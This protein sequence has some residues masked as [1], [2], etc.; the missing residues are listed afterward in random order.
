ML[1][2]GDTNIYMDAT[3]NPATEHFRAGWEACVFPEGHS[4]RRGRHH[5]HASPVPAPGGHLPGQ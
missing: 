5:P 2:A 4:R 3:T 1:I